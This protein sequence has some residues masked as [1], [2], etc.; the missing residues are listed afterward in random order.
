MKKLVILLLAF[1]VYKNIIAQNVAINNDGSSAD[2]SA[3]LDIKSTD[4]G[5]L[6]PRMTTAQRTIIASPATGLLVFDNTVGSFWFYNGSGWTELTGG[7]GASVWAANGTNIYNTNTGNVG[8]GLN[9]P[10]YKLHISRP[11]PNIGFFDVAKN[12]FSGTVYG[13]STDLIVNAYSKSILGSNTSGNLLLQLSSSGVGGIVAGNVGI[14]TN[15]PFEK[16]SLNGTLGLYNGSTRYGILSN[17]NGDLSINAKLGFLSPPIPAENLILQ[18]TSTF[19]ITSGKIGIGT[20]DPQAKLHIASNVMIGSGIPATGYALSVNGKIISQELKV[21]LNAN[22]PDYVFQQHYQLIPLHDLKKFIAVNKHL[23]NIPPAS[24]IEKNG[25][26]VGDMQRRI[27]EKIEE[28][29]LYIFQ[30]E[31]KIK[32]LESKYK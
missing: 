28:L 23:P 8:I 29:T 7:G 32:I 12:H 9:N 5:M 31:E 3:A 6:V 22:W 30:L 27:I 25:L 10:T 16:L 14:G 4:K 24:E 26:D 1:V 13:D 15:T 18:Y 19:G 11:N 17:S 21:Q 20:N 2:V